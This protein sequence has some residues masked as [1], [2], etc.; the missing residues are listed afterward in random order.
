VTETFRGKLADVRI[1]SACTTG[2]SVTVWDDG[3]REKNWNSAQLHR[4]ARSL[5]L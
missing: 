5:N 1:E 3:G 4:W 2:R